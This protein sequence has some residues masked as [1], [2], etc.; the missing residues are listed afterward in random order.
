MN[1]LKKRLHFSPW[2]LVRIF[3]P[4]TFIV[5]MVVY[6][7]TLYKKIYPGVPAALTASAAKISETVDLSHPIFNFFSRLVA[8]I[9][10]ETLPIRLNLFSATCGA[11][12]ITF[13]YLLVARIIFMLS[14]EDSGGSMNALP[15]ELFNNDDEDNSDNYYG[16]NAAAGSLS[17]NAAESI[18]QEVLQHN[19]RAS[20]SAVMGAFGAA[21]VLAFCGPFWFAATRLYPCTFDLMLLFLILNLVISYDQKENN[22]SLLSAVFL[23]AV[24]SVESMLF[25]ILAPLGVLILYRS[26]KLSEQ[27]TTGRILVCIIAGLVGGTLGVVILW[28]A[29]G[30]CLNIVVPATR[31]IMNI[32]KL[33]MI[34]DAATWIPR[35]GW[36]RIFVLLLL[37][38]TLAFFLFAYSFKIR[39]PLLFILQLLLVAMLIPS[40]INMNISPW[41][42]ARLISKVPV[43]SYV[44]LATFTGLLIAAW[45]LMREMYIE[46]LDDELDFYEYRDNPFVCKIG[47]ILCWPLLLLALY[48][49]FGCYTDIDP[50]KGVFT[51]EVS[52][53]IYEQI[54]DKKFVLDTPFLKNELLIRAHADKKI[55]NLYS[56]LIM[57]GGKLSQLNIERIKKNPDFENFR[58]RLINAAE[59]SPFSFMREWL[60]LDK[61]AYTQIAV[62]SNPQTLRKFGY[63]AIPKGFFMELVPEGTELDTDKIIT[64][65]MA[66]ANEIEPYMFAGTTD[67]IKLLANHRN[68]YRIQLARTGNELA[69]LLINH[70]KYEDALKILKH[71]TQLAPG[72]LAITLNRYH[73]S[74]DLGVDQEARKYIE[75]KLEEIPTDSE[76]LNL[77]LETLQEKSG[78]L[79][80]PS[81]LEFAKKRFWTKSNLFRNLAV[82]QADIALDP[83]L[84]IRNKKNELYHTIIQKIA[85]NELKEADSQLNILLDFDDNDHF[86]LINKAKVAILQ[87]NIP[88]AGLWMDLAKESS[89]DPAKLIWHEVAL[90]MLDNKIEDA[91]K[92]LNEVIPDHTSNNDLWSLLAEILIKKGEFAELQNRV[93]PALHG[94]SRNQNNYMFYVVRG[95][96]LKTRG[97]QEYS[98]ARTAFIKA[99]ELN[100]NQPQVQSQILEL[101]SQLEVPAFSEQDAIKVLIEEPEHPRA[102]YLMGQVRLSRNQ[103]ELAEDFFVRSL[104][105]EVSAESLAGL[106]ET[107]LRKGDASLAEKYI[108][109]S[110]QINSDRTKSLHIKTHILLTLGKI[111]EAADCFSAVI[112]ELPEDLDVRLTKIQLQI[113][114]G[115]LEEAAMSVSNMLEREDYLPRPIV[116]QLMR[117]AGQLSQ[118]LTRKKHL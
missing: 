58:P 71:C 50:K 109:K 9:P 87:K 105:A 31:P 84:A 112:K 100:K 96:I 78:T 89:V 27:F 111:D 52:K 102:N 118:E 1:F 91:R 36:S 56:T 12:A 11:I 81:I 7:L 61:Q 17:Q 97:S 108:N 94:S 63:M 57:K 101:D 45:H 74:K 42:I 95:Y 79:A 41:G 33:T 83:I 73:L 10:Y 22:F 40:L 37:P 113:K 48:V 90:L 13:F 54:K 110:L 3:A 51:D 107:I 28:D 103:L 75:L 43:Y 99:M 18:P 23:L 5:P 93:Y 29:A 53:I 6:W 117:L 67:D 21:S 60:T 8:E 80:D 77:S 16:V 65:F 15:P 24:C 92:R 68:A 25:L 69:I 35:F 4:I 66:F 39:K 44:A 38:S 82:N 49:P 72:N 19:R 106:A 70:K 88:E 30:Y 114:Q 86:A 55:I 2:L 26:M 104:N 14:C 85:G 62:F 59:I 115:R 20:Y 116:A 47:S 64:D 46:K 34:N 32:F 98:A 76:L